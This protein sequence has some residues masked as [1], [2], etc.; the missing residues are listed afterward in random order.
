MPIVRS[1]LRFLALLAALSLPGAVGAQARQGNDAFSRGEA[2][3][4]R[5]QYA[6]AAAAYR[7]ALASEP[8]LVPALLGLERV[9]SLLG[10]SDSLLPVLARAI[11]LAP[12][13]ATFRTAELRTLQSIGDRDAMRASFER[14]RR[15]LPRDPAPYREYARMLLQDGSTAAADTVLRLARAMLGSERGLAY[16]TAQLRAA[17]GLWEPAARAWRQA[18]TDDTYLAQA[19]AFSLMPTPME[20]RDAVRRALAAPP[21]TA[22]P[23]TALA[24]LELGWGSPR[25]G[26]EA[27][28]T[29]RPDTASISAWLDFAGRAEN[30]GAWLVAREALMAVDSVRPSARLVARAASAAMSGGDPAGAA[31]LAERAERGL[32]SSTI[33]HDLL[34]VHLRALS[35]LGKPN[36]AE[37]LLRAYSTR[38]SADQRARYTRLLAW[39]W[40]RTGDLARARAILGDSGEGDDA[41]EGWLALYGGDLAGA[42]SRLTASSPGAPELLTALAFLE[43][44]AAD[45]APEVGE[46]FLAI[47]RGDTL[48]A[49]AGFERAAHALPDA[50]S[51]LLMTAARMYA[52]RGDEQ[53]AT[54]LWESIVSTMP[55]APEAPEAE[56]EWARTLRRGGR[57]AAAIERLEH[58]ILTYPQSALVPQARREL[59]LARSA[60]PP[61]S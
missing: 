18:V 24:Q 1:S 34:P 45:R 55:D 46:A 10:R 17:N 49:A 7:E 44:T 2:L 48:R 54:L 19:A 47:A 11:S 21:P 38:L 28:R 37:R 20:Q 13:V 16:E 23:L 42:R 41:I 56:L 52:A 27:L 51:L 31:A 33:A 32:D 53:R 35:A 40:V 26:W 29:L 9:Y 60:V 15:D 3:E 30:A 22:G 57:E 25:A 14:W 59:E 58:L 5:D 39:G 36:D 61:N 4:A 12:R 6:E 8:T 50:A 43:R